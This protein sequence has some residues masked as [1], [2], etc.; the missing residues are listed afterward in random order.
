M[1][2]YR[3]TKIH[4]FDIFEKMSPKQFIICSYIQIMTLNHI[5][6]FKITIHN[7]KHTQS[8]NRRFHQSNLFEKSILKKTRY[9]LESA[10]SAHYYGPAGNYF[11]QLFPLFLFLAAFR[12]YPCTPIY[13]PAADLKAECRTACT[14][15]PLSF[16][17]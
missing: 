2:I 15:F 16:V 5:K 11:F 10:L 7:T 12:H 3:Y 4:F 1:Y 14:L 13:P 8:N 6:T 9:S 17:C